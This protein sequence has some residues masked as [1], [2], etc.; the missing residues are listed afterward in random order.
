MG[1]GGEG[2]LRNPRLAP[3]ATLCRP[4]CGLNHQSNLQLRTSQSSCRDSKSAFARLSA[5]TGGLLKSISTL[6]LATRLI[7]SIRQA[8]KA[9]SPVDISGG[10]CALNSGAGGDPIP[11]EE[12]KGGARTNC[13]S[14]TFLVNH[15]G[16]T[17]SWILRAREKMS[18]N[19]PGARAKRRGA[20]AKMSTNCRNLPFVRIIFPTGRK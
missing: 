1:E 10:R 15:F 14:H 19:F 18:V 8:F 20:Q 4:L 5:V 12:A 3:W 7:S 16:E 2:G 6:R 11:C 13:A 9:R 17:P